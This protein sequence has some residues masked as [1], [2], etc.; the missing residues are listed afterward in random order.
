[1]KELI[2]YLAKN[3]AG[4]PDEVLVT[5]TPGREAT[6]LELTVADEDLNLIIG[7]HGRTIKAMRSLLAA[8][9]A[10]CGRRFTLKIADE[11]NVFHKPVGTD[12]SGPEQESIN[13]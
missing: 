7:K 8:S 6:L 4:K 5:E 3:L 2:N 13:D 9:S 10:K 11:P 12:G 1:M